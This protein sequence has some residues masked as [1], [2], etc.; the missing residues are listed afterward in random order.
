M[1]LKRY[2]THTHKQ[3][4][5]RTNCTRL[6]QLSAV[7]LGNLI[8]HILAHSARKFWYTCILPGANNPKGRSGKLHVVIPPVV[9]W[10]L[11]KKLHKK[12]LAVMHG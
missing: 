10:H 7:V 4:P 8:L 3:S 9:E 1:P 5:I 6:K 12:C 11:Q 2:N